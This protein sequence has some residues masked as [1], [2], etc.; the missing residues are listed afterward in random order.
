[1]L[2]NVRFIIVQDTPLPVDDEAK[3]T[4]WSKCS[5][6]ANSSRYRYL[7]C[8]DRKDVR[9]CPKETQPCGCKFPKCFQEI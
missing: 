4:K 6:K 1:M 5:K 8:K 3:Y 7:K 2:Q 9:K